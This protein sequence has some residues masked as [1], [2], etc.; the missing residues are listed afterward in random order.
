MAENKFSIEFLAVSLIERINRKNIF[1][2]LFNDP[3]SFVPPPGS[4]SRRSPN[5]FLICRKNVHKEAKRRG[6]QNMRVIS[7]AASILWNSASIEEKKAY[8]AIAERVY[9]I[10]LL[11]NS[12]FF[13]K[14]PRKKSSKFSSFSHQNPNPPLPLLSNTPET[15]PN[16]TFSDSRLNLISN[17]DAYFN[18][19]NQMVL[20]DYNDPDE[21]DYCL[22]YNGYNYLY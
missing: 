3:E 15:F 14:H 9:E 18:N 1:P 17:I 7:K 12:I 10:H 2:P 13:K 22:P 5:S 4:R 6:S 19:D 11:R 8:K 21:Q 16:I 20:F